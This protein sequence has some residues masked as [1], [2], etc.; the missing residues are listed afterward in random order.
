MDKYRYVEVSFHVLEASV[1]D[2]GGQ[3]Y[4]VSRE[5]YFDVCN[6][7]TRGKRRGRSPV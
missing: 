4:F 7:N 5:R 2:E 1:L 3:Q 6:N